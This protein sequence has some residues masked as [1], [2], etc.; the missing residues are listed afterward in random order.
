MPKPKGARVANGSKVSKSAAAAASATSAPTTTATSQDQTED[1]EDDGTSGNGD[2]PHPNPQAH[3]IIVEIPLQKKAHPMGPLRRPATSAVPQSAPSASPANRPHSA[4]SDVENEPGA[5]AAATGASPSK[6]GPASRRA[7][8]LII[9]SSSDSEPEPSAA[10][11]RDAAVPKSPTANPLSPSHFKRPST[12]RPPPTPSSSSSTVRPP[13]QQEQQQ[14]SAK[15]TPRAKMHSA[16]TTSISASRA[17]TS[18]LSSD[19]ES[20]LVPPPRPSTAPTPPTQPVTPSAAAAAAA[21]ALNDPKQKSRERYQAL[22]EFYRR[23]SDDELVQ[24]L[25]TL[26]F[27][28]GKNSVP[29]STEARLTYQELKRRG[30]LDRVREAIDRARSRGADGGDVTHGSSRTAS[31]SLNGSRASSPVVVVAKSAGK[32]RDMSPAGDQQAWLLSRSSSPATTQQAAE[33]ASSAVRPSLPKA[34]SAAIEEVREMEVEMGASKLVMDTLGKLRAAPSSAPP[35]TLQTGVA[36]AAQGRAKRKLFETVSDDEDGLGQEDR[37]KSTL[38]GN[39]ED[40]DDEI[41]IVRDTAQIVL[42]PQPPAVSSSASVSKQNPP[43][44]NQLASVQASVVPPAA[45]ARVASPAPGAILPGSTGITVGNQFQAVQQHPHSVPGGRPTATAPASM[46]T[47]KNRRSSKKR[48]TDPAP[49]PAASGDHRAGDSAS[50]GAVN[51]LVGS[52]DQWEP[53]SLSTSASARQPP[54]QHQPPALAAAQT[55]AADYLVQQHQQQLA[56]QQAHIPPPLHPSQSHYAHSQA[57]QA[58]ALSRLQQQTQRHA[59]QQAHFHSQLQSAAAH[60]QH[61]NGSYDAHRQVASQQRLLEEQEQR[62]LQRQAQVRQ[63]HEQVE[64]QRLLQLQMQ[65][66]QQQYHYPAAPGYGSHASNSPELTT[67]TPPMTYGT[68]LAQNY[69]YPPAPPTTSLGHHPTTGAIVIGS[70]PSAIA[71]SASYAPPHAMSGIYIPSINGAAAPPAPATSSAKPSHKQKHHQASLAGHSPLSNI[72]TPP[73]DQ[74]A[75]TGVPQPKPPSA[76]ATQSEHRKFL[77]ETRDALEARFQEF[78][79]HVSVHLDLV[80]FVC[81]KQIEA[82][83]AEVKEL[84]TLFTYRTM[85]DVE[86]AKMLKKFK[87]DVFRMLTGEDLVDGDDE[88]PQQQQQPARRVTSTQS[89]SNNL[90]PKLALSETQDVQVQSTNADQLDQQSAHIGASV[91]AMEQDT[92]DESVPTV[93]PGS[94]TRSPPPAVLRTASP[95]RSPNV[96]GLEAELDALTPGVMF[97]PVSLKCADASTVQHTARLASSPHPRPT[98]GS[99]PIRSPTSSSLTPPQPASPSKPSLPSLIVPGSPHSP[100]Q[101]ARTC[102][103]VSPG[104]LILSPISVNATPTTNKRPLGSSASMPP[105]SMPSADAS[106][107][108][109]PSLDTPMLKLSGFVTSALASSNALTSRMSFGFA[110]SIFGAASDDKTKEKRL[111][112]NSVKRVTAMR[113]DVRRGGVVGD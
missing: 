26:T 42:I 92:R 11:K 94:P 15:S 68:S 20:D 87:Y 93:R 36:A 67:P 95:P 98:L 10:P 82:V 104:K 107:L 9:D 79:H 62:R 46:D 22:V 8:T 88:A 101:R 58:M 83:R 54:Q 29:T 69:S 51:Q 52:L 59:Q 39:E 35:P 47:A 66:Q 43:L 25:N 18:E 1:L 49:P 48:K 40:D 74:L 24:T 50:S 4:R 113:K 5:A 56:H 112:C 80:T 61:H 6:P 78:A 3:E 7:D 81:E 34:L 45:T 103:S 23:K 110:S 33:S 72:L 44:R 100:T 70:G 71:S 27:R 16:P 28:L 53:P 73:Y 21:A 19:S 86:M 17:D 106:L 60:G 97:P 2:P 111:A 84:R 91:D 63:R 105:T 90:E 108:R 85:V 31:P 76:R 32:P 37:D 75:H 14:H 65:R 30:L 13:Q 55:S 89:G 77:V 57:E 99:S 102:S 41:V 12:S 96:A 109:S 64:Q 38:G